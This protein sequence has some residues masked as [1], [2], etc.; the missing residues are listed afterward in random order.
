M[1][2]GTKLPPH[3]VT[4]RE[5]DYHS[6]FKSLFL[7]CVQSEMGGSPCGICRMVLQIIRWGTWL[8]ACSWYNA[9]WDE[10][11]AVVETFDPEDAVAIVNA[12]ELIRSEKVQREVKFIADTY[13]FIVTIIKNLQTSGLSVEQQ[14]GN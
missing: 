13:S 14:G 11:A 8:G 12:Q 9:H 10:V 1:V 5:L 3:V 2:P 6:A 7:I 4:T